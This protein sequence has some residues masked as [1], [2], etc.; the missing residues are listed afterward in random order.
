MASD[1]RVAFLSF[2]TEIGI[3]DYNK[4]LTSQVEKHAPLKVRMVMQKPNYKWMSTDIKKH[5]RIRRKM[6]RMWWKFGTLALRQAFTEQRQCVSKLMK[7]AKSAYYANEITDCGS[8]KKALYKIVN[9]LTHRKRP[10]ALPSFCTA[11]ETPSVFSKHFE[12]K[13]TNMHDWLKEQCTCS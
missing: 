12:D 7:A 3:D 1:I 8:D 13:I 9:K 6:E 5:Q 2:D 4:I 10:P 11:K